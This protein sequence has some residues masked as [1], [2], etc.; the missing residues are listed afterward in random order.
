MVKPAILILLILLGLSGC[1]RDTT[2]PSSD[3]QSP[4]DDADT[5]TMEANDQDVDGETDYLPIF[6]KGLTQNEISSRMERNIDRLF[7]SV[8]ESELIDLPSAGLLVY[9][10]PNS[11]RSTLFTGFE[12]EQGTGIIH[13]LT[14]P[15]SLK[16]SQDIQKIEL[17]S[18]TTSPKK[19]VSLRSIKIS[20]KQGSLYAVREIR[21]NSEG[22]DNRVLAS[23]NLIFGDG[24]FS[25]IVKGTFDADRE[26]EVGE[27]M[28]RSILNTRI[29]DSPRL[30]PGQDVDFTITPGRLELTD[31][32]IDK[33]I[34]ALDGEFPSNSGVPIFQAGR[35]L[36]SVEPLDRPAVARNLASPGPGYEIGMLSSIQEVEIDDLPGFEIL[37]VG[38]DL[39]TNDP[40]Q[41]YS[42]SLFDGKR[43]YLMNGWVS[44]ENRINY[45]PDF[46]ALAN[47]FQR[48]VKTE[49][50]TDRDD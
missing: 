37:A 14:N 16:M 7:D 23:Y 5:L 40:L 9:Q 33:L 22:T 11:S 36:L 12:Y 18:L 10:P 32:F 1:G 15:F 4:A 38:T 27:S 44:S 46:R 47:S 26:S 6:Q 45:I 21:G 43:H 31:G 50:A 34:F 20:G 35:T 48:K 29:S 39:T 25:W 42:V 28:F 49:E 30:P 41:F 17:D 2:D 13:Y 3:H 24:D 8:P 19:V